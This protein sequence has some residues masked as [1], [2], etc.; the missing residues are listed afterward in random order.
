MEVEGV[1]PPSSCPAQSRKMHP[2]DAESTL[3]DAS[4]DS[5][6]AD[7]RGMIAELHRSLNRSATN[8][9]RS[10]PTPTIHLQN[11][12][13]GHERPGLPPP[14][15]PRSTWSTPSLNPSPSHR[16]LHSDSCETPLK[17]PT[18]ALTHHLRL[19]PVQHPTPNTHH[20]LSPLSPSPIQYATHSASP[21]PAAEPPLSMLHS[22]AL[23]KPGTAVRSEGPPLEKA[24]PPTVE[25][26][27]RA[28]PTSDPRRAEPLFHLFHL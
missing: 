5:S 11:R 7:A 16:L 13:Q 15:H 6:G 12:H 18:D 3:S 10:H 28:S 2:A 23:A 21:S 27:P 20:P 1:S 19:H 25:D 17:M 4:D 22:D 14:H 24:P 9:G 26:A 8:A